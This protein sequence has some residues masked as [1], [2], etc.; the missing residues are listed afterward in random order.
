MKAFDIMGQ[1]WNSNPLSTSKGSHMG[2][3]LSSHR[4]TPDFAAG[5]LAS[6]QS[7]YEKL[8]AR[9]RNAKGQF[10]A[11]GGKSRSRASLFPE[12]SGPSF[13]GSMHTRSGSTRVGG[14]NVPT[15]N[16]FN[17][18]VNPETGNVGKDLLRRKFPTGA[19]VSRAS[20]VG[21]TASIAGKASISA[22][23]GGLAGKFSGVSGLRMARYAGAAGL[24]LMAVNRAA[25]SYDSARNGRMGGAMANAAFGAGLAYA[26]Y[27]LGIARGAMAQHLGKMASGGATKLAGR[28]GML[29]KIGNFMS[30]GL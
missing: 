30:H 2:G 21:E 14:Y 17:F 19:S 15:Y 25:K 11:G 28:G 24:G 3:G 23:L 5:E 18:G 16:K 29:G 27:D 6:R 1:G 10:M 20:V 4:A 13:T 12:P 8:F 22:E 7:M 9:P 26:A